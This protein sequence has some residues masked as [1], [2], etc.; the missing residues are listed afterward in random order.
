MRSRSAGARCSTS[1][2]RPPSRAGVEVTALGKRVYDD[3]LDLLERDDGRAVYRIY[4]VEPGSLEEPGTDTAAVA[5]GRIAITPLHF[6]L[7]DR[8]GIDA[9]AGL[10]LERLA[11]L[12]EERA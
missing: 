5:E 10:D 3:A 9:L 1:T 8:E 12:A 11:G 2:S 7:A 4:G 6:D